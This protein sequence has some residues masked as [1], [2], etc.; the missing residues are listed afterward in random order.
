MLKRSIF[1]AVVA[2]VFAA[3]P[4]RAEIIEQVLVK[5]NGEIITKREFEDRQVAELRNRPELA[6][7]GPTS[8]ELQKAI[9]E[10]TPDLILSAVDDLLLIQRG[11]ENGWALG[12]AQFAQMVDTIKKSNNIED[13]AR[14]QDA[15]KQ[16]G[17]TM[18]DLRRNME[19]MML[20][21]QVQRAEIMDKISI[22]DEEA[23]AYYTQHRPEFTS[24][25]ELTL[26]EILLEVPSSD[27]GV[28]VAEDDA[29]RASAEELR[30]RLL[31]GEP[32]ARLAGESSVASSKANGGLIGPIRSED[33][34]PSL[35]D[36]FDKMQVGDITSVLRTQRG[37]QILKLE[38]R[39]E[40]K[41]KS[42][43]ESRTEIANKIGELKIR[44]ER[45]KY[46]D[47]LRDQATITW[48]ND[49][50]KKAYD[51]ALARRHQPVESTPPAANTK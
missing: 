26:R 47:R 28:N 16:E 12:D 23:R 2:A 21:Q 34:A 25:T 17:L 4:L 7:A 22:N 1:G 27:R 32:F 6:K 48:R 42:F 46:L 14:F 49:E 38:A 45:E 8:P 51:T 10:V 50:L 15:L 41:I 20:I 18:V 40:S 31:A 11:R 29:V 39:S 44:T 35:R 24:P 33:L 30:K 9:A 43:E 37:Y 36:T 5:V 3:V 13:E 19:R